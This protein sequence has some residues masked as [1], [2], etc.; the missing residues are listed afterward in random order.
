M[1][2]HS[3]MSRPL[4]RV[5]L[6]L[7]PLICAP[8]ALDR[9]PRRSAVRG[10][11]PRIYNRTRKHVVPMIRFGAL[12]APGLVAT[13]QTESPSSDSDRSCLSR[14]F[15]ACYVLRSKRWAIRYP[16]P[17]AP[18]WDESTPGPRHQDHTR[19]EHLFQNAQGYGGCSSYVLLSHAAGIQAMV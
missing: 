2:S 3:S 11:E 10:C 1:T 8:K 7:P 14:R 13:R 16:V 19:K 6:P 17:S 15:G 18:R 5:P 9:P 12:R 4:L